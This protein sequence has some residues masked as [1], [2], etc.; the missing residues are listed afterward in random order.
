M[1]LRF[2]ASRLTEEDNLEQLGHELTTAS[3]KSPKNCIVL[4][5]STVEYV[6]SSVIGKWISLHRRLDRDGGKMAMFG[7]HS[8]LRD[9]LETSRLLTY[10]HVADDLQ[11][12][13]SLIATTRN[14]G[15]TESIA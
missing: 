13:Q 2:H 1:V 8:G 9:I 6:T 12:A 11:A 5:V 14:S 4:D 3:E 7:V 10:F 15:G